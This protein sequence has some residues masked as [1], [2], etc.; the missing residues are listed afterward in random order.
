MDYLPLSSIILL[1]LAALYAVLSARSEPGSVP[2]RNYATIA[3]CFVV[4]VG[5]V[6]IWNAFVRI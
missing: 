1:A 2:R 4:V 3:V 6:W 5:L